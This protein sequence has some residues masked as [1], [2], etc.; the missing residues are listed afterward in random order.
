MLGAFVYN[1]LDDDASATKTLRIGR[2]VNAVGLDQTPLPARTPVAIEIGVS[3]LGI[4]LLM[5]TP[6]RIVE[7][8]SVRSLILL[9]L[10]SGEKL[11]DAVLFRPVAIHPGK[12]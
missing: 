7:V 4:F 12:R 1:D 10:Q 5:F 9:A 6:A 2:A 8:N 3:V 11:V